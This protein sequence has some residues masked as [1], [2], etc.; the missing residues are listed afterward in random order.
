[1]GFYIGN[2]RS[3]RPIA[4]IPVIYRVSFREAVIRT[5]T[6]GDTAVLDTGA[7]VSNIPRAFVA[8]YGLPVRDWE[9]ARWPDGRVQRCNVYLLEVNVPGLSA[10]VE[11]FVDYG[12]EEVIL[13]RPILNRWRIVLDPSRKGSSKYDI[14]I[15]D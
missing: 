5:V 2:Y 11:R 7:D 3:D 1:M 13:G 10:V 12:F 8:R 4:P 9:D 15:A 14:E 6:F